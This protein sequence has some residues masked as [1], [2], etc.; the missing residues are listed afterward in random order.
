[1]ALYIAKNQN[2]NPDPMEGSLQRMPPKSTQLFNEFASL[3]PHPT[4]GL[5]ALLI[6]RITQNIYT[7]SLF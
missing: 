6:C 2:P 7:T 4:L 3:V 5:F 1:M